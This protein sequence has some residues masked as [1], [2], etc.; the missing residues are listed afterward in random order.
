MSSSTAPF[1]PL[2]STT[3]KQT[4]I[5]FNSSA[6]TNVDIPSQRVNKYETQLPIRLDYEASLTYVLFCF[7]GVFF[8]I[9]ETKN[10]YVR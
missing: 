8:L 4:E 10:D 3:G 5:S 9:F 7:S 1:E 2:P 6:F